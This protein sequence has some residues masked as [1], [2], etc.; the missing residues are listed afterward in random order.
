MSVTFMSIANADGKS[1]KAGSRVLVVVPRTLDLQMM[2]LLNSL[3]VIDR[4]F[5]FIGEHRLS[6][7]DVKA[8]LAFYKKGHGNN[9]MIVLSEDGKQ[10]GA[11]IAFALSNV[12]GCKLDL[13]AVGCDGTVAHRDDAMYKRIMRLIDQRKLWSDKGLVEQMVLV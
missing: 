3:K 9:T 6:E 7:A 13:D 5:I 10:T 1:I 4:K 11:A 8:I 2:T 12:T